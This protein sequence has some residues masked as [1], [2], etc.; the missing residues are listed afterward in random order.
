MG[1]PDFFGEEDGK[2]MIN[3]KFT[4]SEALLSIPCPA[5]LNYHTNIMRRALNEMSQKRPYRSYKS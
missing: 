2:D 1:G 3:R 4:S 5:H